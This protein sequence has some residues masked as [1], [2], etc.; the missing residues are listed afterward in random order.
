MTKKTT[1]SILTIA[2]IMPT[3][4]IGILALALHLMAQGS[5]Y[6][7]AVDRVLRLA[8]ARYNRS[9]EAVLARQVLSTPLAVAM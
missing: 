1:A 4:I 5:H 8:F 3:M 7:W 6:V 2:T 9:S